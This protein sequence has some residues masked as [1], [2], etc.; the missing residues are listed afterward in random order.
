MAYPELKV[1]LVISI[2]EL[3]L[4]SGHYYL[5]PLILKILNDVLLIE[6]KC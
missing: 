6:A 1:S 4:L 3:F 5:K 2:G